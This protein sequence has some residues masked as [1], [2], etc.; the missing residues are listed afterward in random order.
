M[1]A[2]EKVKY[3]SVEGGVIIAKSDSDAEI[4]SLRSELLAKRLRSYCAAGVFYNNNRR[5]EL[6]HSCN[7]TLARLALTAIEADDSV[8][9]AIGVACVMHAIEAAEKLLALFSDE[10]KEEAT[11]LVALAAGDCELCEYEEGWGIGKECADEGPGR[12]NSY[13]VHLTHSWVCHVDAWVPK[14]EC[15]TDADGNTQRREDCEEWE[16]DWYLSGWLYE[17]TFV[18]D[19]C[20]T[21]CRCGERAE[22]DA[23]DICDDCDAANHEDEDD[24]DE[25]GGGYKILD[26]SDSRASRFKAAD[27][28][29]RLKLGYEIE[30]ELDEDANKN[31]CAGVIM[32]RMA[33]DCRDNDYAVAK[34][35]SSLDNGFELVSRPDSLFMHCVQLAMGWGAWDHDNAMID[36]VQSMHIHASRAALTDLA[37]GK[38]LVFVNCPDNH[39]FMI[40]I[41]GRESE[42]WAAYDEWK[43]ITYAKDLTHSSDRYSAVNITRK[44]VEF[45]IFKGSIDEDVLIRNLEFVDALCRFSMPANVGIQEATSQGAFFDYVRKN[46]K[47]YLALDRWLVSAGYLKAASK[48]KKENLQ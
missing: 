38:L 1:K 44:T 3:L 24:D 30:I 23:G 11:R 37:V 7:L 34:Y 33:M 36:R 39:Y 8:C 9:W 47:N 29:E 41:A 31:E 17:N 32:E 28:G 46:R 40:G 6:I 35:D 18:C 26:Y 22:Y 43:S 14:S 21:R 10:D 15:V 5:I 27:N 4:V 13:A 45:R 48:P 25:D 12:E 19:Q 20:A 2:Q 42:Q 16:G